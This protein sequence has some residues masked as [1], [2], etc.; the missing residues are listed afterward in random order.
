M[1]AIVIKSGRVPFADAVE[2]TRSLVWRG[3]R[4]TCRILIPDGGSMSEPLFI[5][6]GSIHALHSW[7]RLE[8]RLADRQMIVFLEPP[9]VGDSEAVPGGLTWE[10]LTGAAINTLDALGI[11]RCNLLGTSAGAPTAYRMAQ[12]APERVARLLL[13]GASPRLC[14]EANE[15]LLS[16]ERLAGQLSNAPAGGKGS[17]QAKEQARA[18]VNIFLASSTAAT[19]VTRQVVARALARRVVAL[20]G[21]VLGNFINYNRTLLIG[22]DL[23]PAQEIRGVRTLVLTGQKDR[24]TPPSD[25]RKVAALI[26]GSV[27]MYVRA[28]GHM[29]HNEREAE[30]AD[31]VTRFLTDDSL[32]GLAYCG[33]PESLAVP[34]P[35]EAPA[36]LDATR[37]YTNS[38]RAATEGTDDSSSSSMTTP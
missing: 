12:R 21:H 30:F 34:R 10:H 15:T 18:L 13:L 2:E 6:G 14:P 16:V 26:D 7:P 35:E 24:V 29:V 11:S 33:P 9:G 19:P 37:S 27:F 32:N 25:G 3:G 31:V 5:L 1:D 23:L 36:V 17:R 38:L 8:Q 20:P 28:A 4:Y 22:R